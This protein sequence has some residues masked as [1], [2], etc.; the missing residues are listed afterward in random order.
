M[1]GSDAPLF[2][3]TNVLLL[4]CITVHFIIVLPHF[5]NERSMWILSYIFS[6]SSFITLWLS[7]LIDPGILPPRSFP[8]KPSL[9]DGEIGPQGHRYCNTCNIYRPPRSK[10][11]NSCNVCVS[12]FDHH[13]PWIGNCIGERNHRYFFLFL[14]SISS[15]SI[16]IFISCAR[17]ILTQYHNDNTTTATIDFV[18]H[19]MQTFISIPTIFILAGFALPCAW[20]LTSLTVFHAFIISV[21]QTT[22][23]RVRNVHLLRNYVHK[24]DKGCI[25][26]WM[27]AF[28]SRIVPSNLPDFSETVQCPIVEDRPWTNGAVCQSNKST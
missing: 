8:L 21:A 25:N 5:N 9:P 17:V 12:K 16:H 15:L 20:A 1:L 24:D 11:C 28:C 13:C 14:L 7:S 18:H 26:N 6:I 19:A 22:N 23:E 27:Y 10:H 3:L 2:Y 4:V